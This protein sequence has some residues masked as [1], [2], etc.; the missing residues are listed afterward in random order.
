MCLVGKKRTILLTPMIATTTTT[1]T[2][3]FIVIINNIESE[4][5]VSMLSDKERLAVYL[6][7]FI[8]FF[9]QTS[10]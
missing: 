9:Y 7:T 2:K 10:C 6:A 8:L 3:L 5:A 1:T 4:V